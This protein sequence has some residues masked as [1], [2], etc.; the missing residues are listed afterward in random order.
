MSISIDARG[1]D[2]LR[3]HLREGAARVE[4]EIVRFLDGGL[5]GAK[6][7]MI[8][9]T[10]VKTGELAGNWRIRP[11]GPLARALINE[12][13]YAASVMFGARPHAIPG[14]FGY[15]PPFGENPHFHPGN[16]ANAAMQD[17][18]AAASLT[19]RED[20]SREGK[21]IALGLVSGKDAP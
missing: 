21:R 14:A 5:S 20:W 9:A 12:T 11:M 13:P 15:P 17:A 7:A 2:A 4:G 3:S 10:P 1:L 6:T 19:I 8:A 18:M 16:K